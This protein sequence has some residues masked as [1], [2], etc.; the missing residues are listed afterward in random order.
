[1][2]IPVSQ[3]FSSSFQGSPWGKKKREGGR[4]RGKI[5]L[6]L[7]KKVSGMRT[8]NETNELNSASFSVLK[9]AFLY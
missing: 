6:S 2:I 4:R 1:M 9:L 5:S 7:E 3:E 8:N